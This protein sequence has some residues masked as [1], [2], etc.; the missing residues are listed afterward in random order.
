MD[1][2]ML[3]VT[4]VAID[5]STVLGRSLVH[6]YHHGLRQHLGA[7]WQF[8][9][10]MSVE[11]SVTVRTTGTLPVLSSTCHGNQHSPQL[12]CVQCPVDISTASGD[13]PDHRQPHEPQSS[14]Q[15][16]DTSGTLDTIM[17]S[18]AHAM[19]V[20]EGGPV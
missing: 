20:L 1:T 16:E 14:T 10:Q 11:P 19:E 3:S 15:P 17:T 8:R 5:T 9:A 13:S 18:T 2:I 12:Q 4:A 7:R 6:G